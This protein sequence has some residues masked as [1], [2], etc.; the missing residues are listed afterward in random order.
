MVTLETFKILSV[1]T[2]QDWK[3]VKSSFEFSNVLAG[4]L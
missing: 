1:L 3:K 2:L 4:T